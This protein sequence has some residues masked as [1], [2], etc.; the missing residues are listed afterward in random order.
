MRRE[1]AIKTTAYILMIILALT[2]QTALPPVAGTRPHTLIVMTAAAA[3]FLGPKAGGA[4]G[5]FCG[6]LADWLS[7]YTVVYYTVFLMLAGAVFGLIA[8]YSMRRSLISTYF[9]AVIMLVSNRVVYVLIFILAQGRAGISV[10][11]D[12]AAP[13]VLYSLALLPIFYFPARILQRQKKARG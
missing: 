12:V 4:V 2:L 11:A 6:I 5:F 7:V 1:N 8:D 10:F 3:M 9:I 13:E